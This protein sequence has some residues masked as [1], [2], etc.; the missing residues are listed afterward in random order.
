MLAGPP[1][2][3]ALCD[4]TPHIKSPTS[5]IQI[6]CGHWVGF[7]IKCLPLLAVA[8]VNLHSSLRTA[9]TSTANTSATIQH[10]LGIHSAQQP[11]LSPPDTN[12]C[13]P[14]AVASWLIRAVL[15][16]GSELHSPLTQ[17]YTSAEATGLQAQPTH[18]LPKSPS[19][20]QATHT[21]HTHPSLGLLQPPTTNS[22]D[23][24]AVLVWP[25]RAVLIGGSELHSLL[26]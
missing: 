2:R 21:Q 4:F 10:P 17:S 25:I 6:F 9:T 7:F 12:S 1:L 16:G 18:Q 20:I 3:R 8:V 23:P 13:D 22:L 14:I 26:T 24:I 5:A 15:I 11:Y 19:S